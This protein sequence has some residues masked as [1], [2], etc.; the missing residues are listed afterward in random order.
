MENRFGNFVY[1]ISSINRYIRKIKTEELIDYN[2]KGTHIM[3]LYYIEKFEKATAKD[4]CDFTGEDKSAISR[5]LEYL[6][7]SYLIKND[8]EDG[9]KY[10]SQ[11][12]LTEDGIVVADLVGAKIDKA[13][14]NAGA[15]I[16]DEEREI[17][18][19]ALD[20]INTNLKTICQ[21]Y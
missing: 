17:M 9:K 7:S 16:S 3:C 15:G 4:L 18:Y 11:Y 21:K 6:E 10:K 20:V 8:V 5:A 1:L 19:R 12:S 2:L 13:I 14:S